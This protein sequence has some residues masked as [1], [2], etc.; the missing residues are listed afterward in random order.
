MMPKW[1]LF[2]LAAILDFVLAFLAYRDGRTFIMA[3]LIFAGV[4]FIIA[5]IGSVKGSKRV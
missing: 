4:L 2:G 5:A 1:I 3:I